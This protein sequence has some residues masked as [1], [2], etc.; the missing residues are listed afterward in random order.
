MSV[1]RLIGL[2][3]INELSIDE[4]EELKQF[5]SDF[6]RIMKE[7]PEESQTMMRQ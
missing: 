4:Q 6:N 7:N 1:S 2:V 5:T 3:N